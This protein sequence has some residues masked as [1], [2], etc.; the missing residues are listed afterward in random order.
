[1]IMW[2][3]NL[4]VR[5]GS[6]LVA[7]F[8]ENSGVISPN[9]GLAKWNKNLAFHSPWLGMQ[10]HEAQENYLQTISMQSSRKHILITLS[11]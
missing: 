2:T 6:K 8:H 11:E 3:W 4:R 7:I 10:N 5:L 1:M 9:R